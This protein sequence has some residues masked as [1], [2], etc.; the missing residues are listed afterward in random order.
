MRLNV[1][2][3]E[4]VKRRILAEP[5]RV[6]MDDWVQVKECGTVGCIAGHAVLA[7]YKTARVVGSR[8]DIAG[9]RDI[10]IGFLAQQR[11]GIGAVGDFYLSSAADDLFYYSPPKHL[12]AGTK[13]YARA[14]ARHID[15]F[16]KKHTQRKDA[17]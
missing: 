10:D 15:R 12:R 1:K 5:A 17:R 9:R 11:L 3:L 8:C 13:T 4:E 2:L 6:D 14:V 7:S 16:I